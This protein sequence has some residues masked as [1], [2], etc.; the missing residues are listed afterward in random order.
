MRI[1][2]LGIL[3]LLVVWTS[4]LSQAHAHNYTGMVSF[5]D[6]L[7]DV[8]NTVSLL[9]VFGEEFV[10]EST[11]YNSFFYY[12][13]RFSN[14]PV[15]SE[16]LNDQFG[17]ST[18][19]RNNGSDV[20]TG[21][22]FA[23]GGSTSGTGNSSLLLP[24]LLTQVDYYTSQLGTNE[25]LPDPAS[26]LYTVWSG[27]ND[28]INL[29]GSGTPITPEQVA[30]NISTAITNLYNAGGRTFLVP[31]LPPLGFKP[32]YVFDPPKK[33]AANEFVDSYN[34]LLGNTLDSLSANLAGISIV[35]LDIHTLFLDIIDHPENFGFTN[36]TG[37]A[38]T[39]FPGED[40]PS[41]FGSVV[42]NPDEYMFWD[43]SHGTTAV[44]Q[45][46]ADIAYQAIVPEPSVWALLLAGVFLLI[47]TQRQAMRRSVRSP[48]ARPWASG[49]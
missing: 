24:N 39:P 30:A 12:N 34:F 36:V 16:R 2:L 13:Q 23:W 8:G 20:L 41:P 26:S 25:F 6:S 38:Y 14:G 9:S 45:M 27:G 48:D 40:P 46:I 18:M 37:K 44:N 31:N 5:G 17:F 49:F 29:V 32:D 3:S 42:P 33:L 11:G 7:S 22:N 43:N 35:H 15:W 1:P 10:R 19:Q 21:S 47:L 28:V 4:P